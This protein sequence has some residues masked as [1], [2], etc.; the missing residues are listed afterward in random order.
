MTPK[1]IV[2]NAVYYK[3]NGYNC[4]QAVVKALSEAKEIECKNLLQATAGFATGM[5]AMGSTCG[6]LIGA[7]LIVG[8]VSDGKNTIDKSRD[9]FQKF[10]ASCGATICKD[11]KGR[12]TG[13]ELCSC[14]DCVS[15]AVISA[16]EVMN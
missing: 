10:L 2:E 16:L 3:Q 11:L 6:A 15:N 7:N 9:L 12:D 4:A 14:D 8:L 1:E 13:V 5:G